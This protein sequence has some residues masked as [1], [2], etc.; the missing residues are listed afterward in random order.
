MFCPYCAHQIA[1]DAK[2]CSACGKPLSAQP[3]PESIGEESVSLK[4]SVLQP[5][6]DTQ[7]Q[8]DAEQAKLVAFQP[9]YI[10]QVVAEPEPKPRKWKPW[11]T[12]TTVVLGTIVGAALVWSL[13]ISSISGVVN[14]LLE[15]SMVP[16]SSW[17]EEFFDAEAEYSTPAQLM[18]TWSMSASDFYGGM[19][20]WLTFDEDTVQLELQSASGTEDYG[21]FDYIMVGEN[22]FYIPDARQSFVFSINESGNMLTISPGLVSDATQ[23]QWFNFE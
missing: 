1:D 7:E 13:L 10:P 12:V 17:A 8:S 18:R 4:E 19:I 22:E 2:F 23:E 5:S 14:W 21:S 6:T 11:M 15:D 20:L 3:A 9:E 16:A